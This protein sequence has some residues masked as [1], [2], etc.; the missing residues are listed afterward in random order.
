MNSEQAVAHVINRLEEQSIEYMVVG[1]LSCNLYGV[2]RASVDADI[3]VDLRDRS[4]R[5]ICEGL[6]DDFKLDPQLMMEMLT[7]SKRNVLHFIPTGFDIELFY[8]SDD[9]HHRERFQRRQRIEIPELG[10]PASVQTAEDLIIQKLRWARRKDLDDIVNVIAV[11]SSKLDWNFIWQWTKQ[12]GTSEL[13][14]QLKTEALS[15]GN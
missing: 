15:L 6:G 9:A 7:G 3:V 8:L 4:M 14:S 12:H 5:V 13:L 10:R 11:S 2:P 1:A